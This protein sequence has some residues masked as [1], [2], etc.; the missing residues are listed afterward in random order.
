MNFWN[1]TIS[2]KITGQ[3]EPKWTG[4]RREITNHRYDFSPLSLLSYLS[5]FLSLAVVSLFSSPSLSLNLERALSSLSLFID[6]SARNLTWASD[7]QLR[8]SL[9]LRYVSLELATWP[10]GSEKSSIFRVSASD[11]SVS[12]F[13][14]CSFVCRI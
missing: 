2:F 12:F 13:S 3:T 4:G 6:L 11:S 10:S 1:S 14:V 9:W 5:P 7:F 8:K